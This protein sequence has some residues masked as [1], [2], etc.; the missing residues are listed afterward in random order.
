MSEFKTIDEDGVLLRRTWAMPNKNT[1]SI[2]PFKELI[3]K[4][5]VKL[6]EGAIILDPFANTSK[7][8]TITNDIDESCDTTYHMP[9]NEFLQ[10]FDDNSIDMILFDPPYSP[11]QV[12]QCYTELNRTVTWQDTSASFW[13]NLKK[14][15]GRILKPNAICITFGWNSSGI[16]KKYG[17]KIKEILLCCH[18]GGHNDTIAVVDEKVDGE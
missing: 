2:K 14:E 16:G 3:E 8:G 11:N 18:G 4:Y 10:M 12:K 9:A 6:P 13:S 1:F 7:E 5:K 15:I 17:C